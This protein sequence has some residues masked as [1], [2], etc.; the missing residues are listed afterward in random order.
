MKFAFPISFISSS[1]SKT[2]SLCYKFN[3]KAY[4]CL[5]KSALSSL[6]RN[7]IILPFAWERTEGQQSA[8]E[9]NGDGLGTSSGSSGTVHSAVTRVAVSTASKNEGDRVWEHEHQW[10]CHSSPCHHLFLHSNHLDYCYWDSYT[11]RLILQRT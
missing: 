3:K 4:F 8:R 9:K 10:H 5:L 1:S 11:S 2:T 6:L 7:P